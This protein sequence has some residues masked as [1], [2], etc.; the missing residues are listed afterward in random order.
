M[1]LISSFFTLEHVSSPNNFISQIYPLLK[2][3]GIFYCV[4]PNI[5]KN[6]ADLIVADHINRNYLQMAK[7]YKYKL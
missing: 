3:G 5:Y 6:F 2:E 4:V 7:I 1:D